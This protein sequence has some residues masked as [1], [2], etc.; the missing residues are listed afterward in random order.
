M[1]ARHT[2]ALALVDWYLMSALGI[3]IP[4]PIVKKVREHW[5]VDSLRLKSRSQINLNSATWA[6]LGLSREYL[7]EPNPCATRLLR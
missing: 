3:S 2:A 1:N 4:R 7:P 6:Q 5:I